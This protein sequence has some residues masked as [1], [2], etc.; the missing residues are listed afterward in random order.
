MRREDTHAAGA[1]GAEG[2]EGTHLRRGVLTSGAADQLAALVARAADAPVGAIQLVEEDRLRLY[3]AWNLQLPRPEIAATP[4]ADSVAGV[5]VRTGSALV[6]GDLATD[7]RVP[8]G[9]P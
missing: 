5:V 8:E 7:P 2:G 4:L 9:S 3:G 6:V 1:A